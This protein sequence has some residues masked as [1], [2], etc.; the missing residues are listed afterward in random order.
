MFRPAVHVF[1]E[2][3]LVEP[4]TMY[5]VCKFYVI[6]LCKGYVKGAYGSYRGLI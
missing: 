2:A 4:D 3:A 6:R 1:V 5:S